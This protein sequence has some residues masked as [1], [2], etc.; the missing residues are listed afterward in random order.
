MAKK[1][2]DKKGKELREQGWKVLAYQ[3]GFRK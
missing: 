1:E 3:K 2:Y